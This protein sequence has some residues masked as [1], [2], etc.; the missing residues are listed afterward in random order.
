MCFSFFVF[1]LVLTHGSRL[2]LARSFALSLFCFLLTLCSFLGLPSSLS[3]NMNRNVN[4]VSFGLLP[5]YKH[6]PRLSL[7][8][9]PKLT[10]IL[11]HLHTKLKLVN[12]ISL[13]SAYVVIWRGDDWVNTRTNNL[14]LSYFYFV[15][16]FLFRVRLCLCPSVDSS[17]RCYF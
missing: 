4:Y 11:S 10:T 7:A 9:T 17:K 16:S 5:R 2:L 15:F 3:N 12:R 13:K 1:V 8:A 6:V 14:Q